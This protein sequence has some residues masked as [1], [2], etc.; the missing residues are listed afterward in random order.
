M[1]ALFTLLSF[2]FVFVLRAQLQCGI[3]VSDS[4][5]CPGT[6]VSFIGVS[7]GG[8][9]SHYWEFEGLGTSISANP[10]QVFVTPGYYTIKHIVRNSTQTDTC[11]Q[12]IRVFNTPIADFVVTDFVACVF[13]CSGITVVNA[14]VGV[15][16][17]I[18]SHLWDYDDGSIGSEQS[19]VHCYGSEG[20]YGLRLTVVDTN[21]CMASIY[22]AG[23]ILI[24]G[25]ILAT[26]ASDYQGVCST[27]DTLSFSAQVNSNSG[28]VGYNWQFSSGQSTNTPT[29]SAYL[30]YGIHTVSLAVVDSNGCYAFDTLS[31]DLR[32][33]DADFTANAVFDPCPPFPVSFSTASSNANYSWI[34]G[35]GE[36][37]NQQNPNHVYG[38][39]GVYSV[40]LTVTDTSGECTATFSKT[41]Y[42]TVRGPQVQATVSEDTGTI[43]HTVVIDAT[44]TDVTSITIAT[45]DGT[46]YP[47]PAFP[48]IHTFNFDG[49]YIVTLSAENEFGCALV[50]DIDTVVVN[51]TIVNGIDGMVS[52]GYALYPTVS[53]GYVTLN[54]SGMYLVDKVEVYNVLGNRELIIPI[55]NYNTMLDVGSLASGVYVAVLLYNAGAVGQARFIK[56]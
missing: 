10:S 36:T 42:I 24:E 15:D 37:S 30:P 8:P 3:Y 41:D 33:I 40:A 21:G 18:A 29:A 39:S 7:T 51:D 28:V 27:A 13:D 46:V 43:A 11:Y 14:S 9:T 12:G 4:A 2:S 56:K 26:I 38:S 54:T 1:K 20:V 5:V 47:N 49:E 25:A 34:F 23:A 6:N 44:Y 19:F 35:D 31:L 55:A 52:L 32:G 50:L 53:S 48:I 45:G 22:N 17:P 16:A